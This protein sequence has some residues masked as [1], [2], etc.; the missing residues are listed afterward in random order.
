MKSRGLMSS[1]TVNHSGDFTPESA[2]IGM[3]SHVSP[4]GR[5]QPLGLAWELLLW[6][7][8]F[9]HTYRN[10]CGIYLFLL[11]NIFSHIKAM[12]I[13]LGA[14]KMVFFDICFFCSH[15]G[16][17]CLCEGAYVSGN[18]C[19][20]TYPCM[21]V[22]SGGRCWLSFSVT[23]NLIFGNR[24]FSLNSKLTSSTGLF[25][26]WAQGVCCPFLPCAGI[27]DTYHHSRLFVWVLGL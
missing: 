21:H 12:W 19:G 18:L 5:E 23:L 26:Q 13:V 8:Q 25:G 17:L 9:S 2:S 20:C 22:E 15:L 6:A 24:N 10:F 7:L 16:S 27:I 1:N 4:R 3:L 14:S 11:L